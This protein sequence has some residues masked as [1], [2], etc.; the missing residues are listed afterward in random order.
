MAAAC[1]PS[2]RLAG[3]QA[4][5]P[6]FDPI[7]FFA[8][9]TE[10]RG[11]LAVILRHDQPT[12]VEGHGVV[13]P[14][15]TITLDQDVRRGTEAPTHRTW[16]LRRVAPGR[17]AGTLSDASGPVAGDVTGNRLHLRFAMKGGLKAQQWLYLQPGGQVARNRMVVTKFGIP[18]A[19]LDETITR[20]AGP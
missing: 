19:S 8:G 10:G 18:V 12:L 14:V 20:L 3:E 5:A 4:A 15:G 6:D 11:R 2:G 13:G 7:A 16:R 9:H 1:V 17:Y